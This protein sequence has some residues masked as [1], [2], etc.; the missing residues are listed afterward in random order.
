MIPG[1]LFF[2]SESSNDIKTCRKSSIIYRADKPR[3]TVGRKITNICHVGNLY[4]YTM[5]NK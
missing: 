4:T 1:K 3:V 5:V 2:K